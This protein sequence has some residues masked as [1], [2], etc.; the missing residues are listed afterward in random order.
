MF[1][2]GDQSTKPLHQTS[3]KYWFRTNLQLR[4]KYPWIE[5]DII[6]KNDGFKKEVISPTE[7]GRFTHY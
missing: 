4:K 5:V 1:E 3:T 2:K 6:V 7:N